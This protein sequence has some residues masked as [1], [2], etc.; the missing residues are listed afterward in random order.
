MKKFLTKFL[1]NKSLIS[2]LIFNL[3]AITTEY[4]DLQYGRIII[5]LFSDNTCSNQVDEFL[6]PADS[7]KIS[8][9]KTYYHPEL[10]VNSSSQ[11]IQDFLIRFD[12]FSSSFRYFYL[13]NNYNEE[14]EGDDGEDPDID[15]DFYDEDGYILVPSGL[16]QCNG[17]CY[18]NSWKEIS[19]DTNKYYSCIYNNII[20]S[21]TISITKYKD[22]KCKNKVEE[23]KVYLGNETCWDNEKNY[24]LMPLYYE[25]NVKRLYYHEFKHP[26]CI[27]E[28]FIINQNFLNCN[29]RCDKSKDYKDYYYKCKFRANESN[30]IKINFYLEI[31]F[32][33]FIILF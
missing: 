2:L 32:M 24:S 1:I 22:K 30:L 17:R 6:H 29:N 11:E 9:N 8:I 21:A 16:V 3:L 12:F 13:E 14:E 10:K 5:K 7:T 15:E 19:N 23:E 33:V 27:G 28:D 4:Y 25:D 18:S 31:I 26:N 20:K